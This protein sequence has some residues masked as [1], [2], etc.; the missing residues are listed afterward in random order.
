MANLPNFPA[1]LPPVGVI[2]NFKNPENRAPIFV[3]FNSLCL[4]VMWP[5]FVIRI[6]TKS[7]ILRSFGW[8][9]GS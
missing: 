9:D 4:A 7:W 8:D 5:I 1:V 2:P 3:A 6:Y